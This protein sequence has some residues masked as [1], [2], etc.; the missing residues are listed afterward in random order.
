MDFQLLC[1]TLEDHLPPGY[2]E[3]RDAVV[4]APLEATSKKVEKR[5][6]GCVAFL[7]G[8][9]A[10]GASVALRQEGVMPRV[11]YELGSD[12]PVSRLKGHVDGLAGAE[13][14][15]TA[16]VRV[17]ERTMAHGYGFEPDA[18]SPSGRRLHRYAEVSFPNLSSF[19][20]V[21]RVQHE[22][23]RRRLE[24]LL[25]VHTARL[26]EVS[27]RMTEASR[28]AM[29]GRRVDDGD[30]DADAATFRALEEEKAHLAEQVLP[31]LRSRIERTRGDE[32]DP[33]RDARAAE[34]TAHRYPHEHFVEPLS[35][36]FQE[37][38]LSPGRWYRVAIDRPCDVPVTLC[39][40]EYEVDSGGLVALDRAGTAPYV[41]CYY[42]IETTSLDPETHP[43]IQVSLV[44]E[45]GGSGAVDL[46]LEK[47]VVVLNG[48]DEA[49]L[50]GVRCHVCNYEHEVLSTFSRLVRERDPDFVVA[51]NG[52]NFD[53]HFLNVRAERA[54]RGGVAD[55]FYLSRFALRPAQLR[56]LSLSSSGMGDNLYR[57]FDMPGRQTFDWFVKLKRDL[58]SEPSYSLNHFARTVCGDQK[59]DMDHREIPRLQAGTDADRARL[60]E[61][62]VHDSVLLARLNVAR[63]MVIEILQFASVFGVVPEWVYFRG[64]QVRFIT[65]LLR[66]VRTLEPVPLLL[67]VPPTGFVG[68]GEFGKFTGATVNEPRTGFFKRPVL[69]VDWLSL[70]P[71]IMMGHNLCHSTH[72]SPERVDEFVRDGWE[73]VSPSAAPSSDRVLVAHDVGGGRTTYFASAASRRGV[74]PAIL[75]EQAEQ[76]TRAKGLLKTYVSKLKEERGREGGGDPALLREYRTLA[77]V[78]DGQ[79]KAI[80][81]SM[82]SVYGACGAETGKF[83]NR[84]ISSTVTAEG[85]H[86]MVVKKTI[87]PERYPNVD[88]VYGDTD[89]IMMTF[90]D[91]H[92]L[93]E[94]CARGREVEQFITEYFRDV[95]RL[96]TM[97]IEFEKAYYPYLQQGKKRYAGRKYEPG[98]GE[99]M[100][101]KGIDCKGLETE[102][103]D[104]LPFT[105]VIMTD[106]FDE[107]MTSMDEGRALGHFERHMR[108]LVDDEVP[109]DEY[110]MRKNLSAKVQGRVDSIVQAKVNRD[111]RVREPGSEAATGEQVEYV[112]V[113]GWK[114]EK[115]TQLAEDPKFARETGLRPNRLWYFEHAI[116]EPL[117]KIFGAFP[118]VDF[119]GVCDRYRAILNARRLNVGDS[120]RRVMLEGVNETGDAVGGDAGGRV[121]SME[122]DPV[123]AVAYVPRP[124]PPP[125]KKPRPARR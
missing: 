55:F 87:L 46:P 117:R 45:T 69:C 34:P 18:R 33:P 104:T 116:E 28:R 29:Q 50:P 101:D 84:D 113:N 124:P 106:V 54:T 6:D 107:I 125:R 51:Y 100:V 30:R 78:Y 38:D 123:A 76:R 41:T 10:D 4:A 25:R 14:K 61:Y 11:Y 53:N 64:Q 79:Q 47:H 105:K 24:G 2:V 9:T 68:A 49:L 77:S 96:P 62:C 48:V 110:V 118:S 21:R 74:L 85:R 102:R 75:Q 42:D 32:R 5:R 99:E 65:Q 1:A 82:N 97:R 95:L 88:V 91:V 120:L 70:Y 3:G 108:K 31:A 98:E 19:R 80:K 67:N 86:A 115:T 89:S 44:F 63:T 73:V 35:R 36:F 26:D 111:R 23:D 7:F 90:G 112:I 22:V 109:F 20:R 103:R 60:A 92:T 66:K 13:L 94:A 37:E 39:T 17:V 8:R 57:F 12:E 58:T 52:V 83:P 72:V 56:D 40:H 27:R 121:E 93:R 59:K 114:G 122:A 81:T 71:S 43:V 119:K 15:Q 16:G